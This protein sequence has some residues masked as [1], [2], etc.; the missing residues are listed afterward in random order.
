MRIPPLL[1]VLIGLLVVA[2]PGLAQ[3]ASVGAPGSDSFNQVPKTAPRADAVP[4]QAPPNVSITNAAAA[5]PEPAKPGAPAEPV[6]D[7]AGAAPETNEFQQFV[8]GSTGKL[9]P[10]FGYQLFGGAPSTFAPVD[11]IPVT[12]D[13]VLGP[14]DE[15]LLRAWG[16]IDIDYRATVDRNGAFY[17]PKV[18]NV[19]VAGIK[20]QDL[21]PYLKTAIGRV[22]R[23]F[24]LTVNL[25]QLRSI[26]VFV[27]GQAARPGSY[28]V[29]SMSTLINTL[30]ASGGPSGKGS[31]RRIELKRGNQVVTEFD[32]YDLLV[33][34]DKSKD[35]RLLPGDV[36]YI[37]P[38]GPLAAVTGSVNMPAIYEL[39]GR[40]SLEE[41]IAL[42]GGLST[43]AAGEKI[44]IERIANRS[45]R[46]VEEIKFDGAGLARGVA[47]GDLVSVRAISARFDNVV[48]LRGNV[49]VASRSPWRPGMRLRDL[50]PDR[51]ALITPDYW[52]RKNAVANVGVKSA[53]QLS[54]DIKRA[55]AEVNW[56]YAVIE[57]LNLADL[58]STLIPFNLGA[59][60]G[61][62]DPAANLLLQPGDVVTIFSKD[63][64]AVPSAKQTKYVRLEGEINQAGVYRP[65]AGETLR[66]L[67]ARV[68]TLTPQA[69]LYGAEFTRESVRVMQQKKMDEA[70]DRMEREG[71]RSLALR[72]QN[73]INPEDTQAVLAEAESRKTLIAKLRQ[74]KA[75]GRIVLE[76]DADA[77]AR[78]LPDIQL[79]DG[80]RFF[81]PAR[82][83]VVAVLG[84]VY[85]ENT[86]LHKTEKRV[87]DYLA[88]A[89]GLTR[90]ADKERMYILRAD[91]SVLSSLQLGWLSGFEG[92]R[93]MPGDTVVVPEQTDKTTWV[94]NLKD[95][96]QIL[97]QF[98]LGAAA[99]SVLK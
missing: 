65:A 89:G 64:I 23:N 50:I 58:T 4:R 25:G 79:E 66:Q 13:Y 11:R 30:F 82:P 88:Q 2:S 76:L 60:V 27:V 20:Y 83:A 31:M 61:G 52:T 10:L 45:T 15:V 39:K 19:N 9:L 78:N 22:F 51:D 6:R 81:V 92:R 29:S 28:T 69:Y 57:R 40:Q 37:P 98:G 75:T 7:A 72:M 12:A 54:T 38:V 49:A 95:W 24:E 93:L 53:A 90:D 87:G 34:G 94:K 71:E 5:A 3:E 59:V 16:Q 68:G 44:T 47:D 35:A 1:A 86:F 33:K 43:T 99:I 26:Q 77:G 56:D 84:A 73:I 55:I 97:Y 41:L 17:I 96:T 21:Q 42:A 70:L 14:G 85:S 67:A 63:D 74:V 36:I 48:T 32:M 62:A 18:G 46:I 80:D 91:G 8:A